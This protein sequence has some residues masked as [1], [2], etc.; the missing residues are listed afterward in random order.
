[1]DLYVQTSNL[2]RQHYSF[3]TGSN[4]AVTISNS[5]INGQTSYSASCDSHSYWGLELVGSGDQ[6]TFYSLSMYIF[7]KTLEVLTNRCL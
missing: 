2:G 4:N 7:F 3:G 5:F 6:I 1:M